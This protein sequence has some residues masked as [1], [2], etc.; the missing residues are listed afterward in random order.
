MKVAELSSQVLRQIRGMRY[1]R[2]VEKH[3]GPFNWDSKFKYGS[4]EFLNIGGY[5]VLLPVDKERHGNISV[6]RCLV[7][8]D[9][10]SLTLFLKDTTHVDDVSCEFFQAGFVAVCDRFPGEDFFVT[11]LYHEWFIVDNTAPAPP[12]RRP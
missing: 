10:L 6:L 2:I 4:P 7:A 9:E 12:K 3:E 1:D 11:I 5:D 8:K